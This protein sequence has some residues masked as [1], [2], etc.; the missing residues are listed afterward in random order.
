MICGWG[1]IVFVRIYMGLNRGLVSR[2]LRN[3]TAAV[4]VKG[5]EGKGGDDQRNCKQ[6]GA[7]SSGRTLGGRWRRIKLKR[8]SGLTIPNGSN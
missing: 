6:G 4:Y 3:K 2:P 8:F 7:T 5:G 1:R